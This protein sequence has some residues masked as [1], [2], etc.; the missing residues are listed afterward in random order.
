MYRAGLEHILGLTRHGATFR[1]DPTI[2]ASWPR[3]TI[4][5]RFG[6]SR[7]EIEVENPEHRCRGVREAWL[8]GVAVDPA[9]IPLLDDGGI[10]RIRAVISSAK[11]KFEAEASVATLER[12]G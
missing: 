10:H 12:T 7:Y 2:P 9:G 3:Y 6:R 8:D 1:L 4:V 5:W 11:D